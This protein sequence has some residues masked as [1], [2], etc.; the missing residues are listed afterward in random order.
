MRLSSL[1]PI[2]SLWLITLFTTTVIHGKPELFPSAIKFGANDCSFCHQTVVGGTALN[3]RGI[4]LIDER[5]RR[6]ALEIDV[7]WLHERG[8]QADTNRI[9]EIESESAAKTASPSK[10]KR[11]SSESE[12][13]PMD[14]ST[15]WGEWPSYN[16]NLQAQ[17]YSPL[18]YIDATSIHDLE[19]A[20]VWEAKIDSGPNTTGT[21]RR[22]GWGGQPFKA[23]PLMVDGRVF[24]RTR[25]STV[26]AIDAETGVE[27]WEFDPET[28]L[29]PRPA[30]FGWT[31]RGLAYHEQSVCV[32][33][34]P[35]ER[36]ILLT[37]DGW[38]YALDPEDG[39]VI[40]SFGND[41]NVDLTQGLR[42]PLD[43]AQVSWSHPPF[44]CR[45]TI[46][47]G[48]Q[49]ND[50]SQFQFRDSDWRQNLPVGDVR[51][52]DPIT[53]EQKWVFKTIPQEGELGVETWGNDSWRWMGN[54]NVWS[55]FS[56]DP[57]LGHVYLPVT[58][59]TNHMYG[60]DRPGDN[61][62]GTSVVAV[63]VDRGTR[64]WHFQI[65]HHDIWDYDL[66][67]PPVV[68]DIVVDNVPRKVV[69]QVTKV[70]FLFVLDRLT[71]EPVWPVEE[72]PVP[73]S[74]VIGEVASPTQPHPTK[75]PPYE[76]Q[77]L[78]HDDLIDLTPELR[79]RAE[80]LVASLDLGPLYTP[81]SLRGTVLSPGIGGGANWPGAA[82][83]P[84]ERRLYVSSRRAIMVARNIPIARR[85]NEGEVPVTLDTTPSEIP[86]RESWRLLSIEGLPPVNPPWSNITAYDLDQG[87]I[88][89]QVANGVGPQGH[90]L[91]ANVK[92]QLPNLGALHANPGILVLPDL[93][94]MGHGGSPSTLKA[95]DKKTGAE[96][97]ST[98]LIGAFDS[99][100]PISYLL[101]NQQFIAIATGHPFEPARISAFRVVV[102]E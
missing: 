42:R 13:V 85:G 71:G 70:G 48:S 35:C 22:R 12:R 18:P 67:A 80:E 19:L 72:R 65:T 29:R 84:V 99:P 92:D 57:D 96:I 93:L 66:P 90:P 21:T 23:T 98:E 24:V 7:D 30:M 47:V 45:D 58:A 46:V 40:S 31:T 62:F 95:L 76:L 101:G 9:V 61:L 15:N 52:F 5:L 49:T 102:G 10:V 37:S 55:T 4:W 77:G 97:W 87:E 6:N 83:D 88:S 43:R 75:P 91:L 89:W 3:E 73:K 17:K 16:G 25:L 11:T 59:P 64:I 81:I 2:A 28:R 94:I 41:G 54:T 78:T 44:V 69:A 56:C 79:Q 26:V 1:H 82:F 74:D 32:E 60:G 34:T 20:W 27:L 51:G 100:A 86:Y 36:V 68:A 39:D 38:M 14:Y 50:M 63:D 33:G 53:G 8:E